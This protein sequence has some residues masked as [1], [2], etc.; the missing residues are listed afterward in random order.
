MVGSMVFEGAGG[1]R[2]L[3][4]ACRIPFHLSWYL[5]DFMVPSY[6]QNPM[7]F[8]TKDSRLSKF[9]RTEFLPLS[10]ASKTCRRVAPSQKGKFQAS[11]QIIRE[12]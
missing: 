9:E 3:Q 8:T 6:D 11:I 2:K 4:K 5:S 7:K 1:F 10:S 12:T